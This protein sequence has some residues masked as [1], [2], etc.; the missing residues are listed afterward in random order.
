MKSSGN[1]K[2]LRARRRADLLAPFQRGL[3]PSQSFS[4][5]AFDPPE[6]STSDG[7]SDGRFEGGCVGEPPF[8]GR[9]QVASL[10]FQTSEPDPLFRPAGV[11][12]DVLGQIGVVFQVLAAYQSRLT[13]FV[14][15]GMCIL[16]Y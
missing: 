7:D 8:Q 16:Y 9:V 10:G 15:F 13:R 11:A 12:F 2:Q 4:E 1:Q 3:H 14:Q 6:P 5:V